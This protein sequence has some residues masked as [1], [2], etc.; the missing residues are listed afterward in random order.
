MVDLI[1]TNEP[2][3]QPVDWRFGAKERRFFGLAL[4]QTCLLMMSICC[5]VFFAVSYSYLKSIDMDA[6]ASR[7]LDS[8][9]SRS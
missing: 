8:C 2:D 5:S 9:A 3:P 4:L 6:A 7:A 1:A